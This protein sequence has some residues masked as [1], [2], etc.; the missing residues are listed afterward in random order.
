MMIVT[1]DDKRYTHNSCVSKL[2]IRILVLQR[3][4]ICFDDDISNDI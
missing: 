1:D 4:P 2:G 3:I